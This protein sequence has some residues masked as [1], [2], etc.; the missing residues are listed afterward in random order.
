MMMPHQL[1]AVYKRLDP[2]VGHVS[3][4]CNKPSIHEEAEGGR[5]RVLPVGGTTITKGVMPLK[6]KKNS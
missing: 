4:S 6:E 1:V 3:Y 2:A 5:E